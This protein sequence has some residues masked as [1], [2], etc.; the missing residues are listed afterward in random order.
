MLF[1]F[2]A[3]RNHVER[4]PHA[5]LESHTSI[6]LHERKIFHPV[7]AI[8]I[9]ALRIHYKISSTTTTVGIFFPPACILIGVSPLILEIQLSHLAIGLFSLALPN[10]Q[11]GALFNYS[12]DYC[13]FYSI[14]RVFIQGV[15]SP[16]MPIPLF[17]YSELRKVFFFF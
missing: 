2:R 3:V 9:L 1:Y 11:R 5:N 7:L 16:I 4:S 13:S 6:L 14:C 12:F 15:F 17:F 10:V 8:I